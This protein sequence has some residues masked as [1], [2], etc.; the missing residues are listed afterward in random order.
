MLFAALVRLRQAFLERVGDDG[1]GEAVRRSGGTIP[2]QVLGGGFQRLQ[3][4]S[5]VAVGLAY[6]QRHR[7]VVDLELEAPQ[8]ALPIGERA[9]HDGAQLLGPERLEHEHA[10]A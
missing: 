9:P 1:G 10:T 2:G 4:A 3:G 6:E 8:A 5:R 7:V